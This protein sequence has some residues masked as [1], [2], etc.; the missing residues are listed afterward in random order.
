M[1]ERTD[2]VIVGAGG[3]GAVLGL[4]LAQKGIKNVVL[5]QAPGP[6]T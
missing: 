2:V 6:P 4:A 3:G 5:E 1:T